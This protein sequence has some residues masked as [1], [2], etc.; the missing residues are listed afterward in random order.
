MAHPPLWPVPAHPHTAE[1]R[2]SIDDLIRPGLSRAFPL[3]EE[4]QADERFGQLFRALAQRGRGPDRSQE[5]WAALHR[6]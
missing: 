5:A 6:S 3:P 4:P 1:T 2:T